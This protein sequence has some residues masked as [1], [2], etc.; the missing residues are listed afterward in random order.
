MGEKVR[1][2]KQL[3]E[4]DD[5]GFRDRMHPHLHPASIYPA[6]T[7][8]YRSDSVFS[9]YNFIL[10]FKVLKVEKDTA[11]NFMKQA[12]QISRHEGVIGKKN[13]V[14]NKFWMFYSEGKMGKKGNFESDA[15][16]LVTSCK[17]ANVTGKSSNSSVKEA[18]TSVVS[19]FF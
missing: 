8:S 11:K 6:W 9:R 7:I 3:K 18:A 5:K 10:R 4:Q 16:L 1:R 17:E 13:L 19:T 2:V 12:A 15:N 14:S